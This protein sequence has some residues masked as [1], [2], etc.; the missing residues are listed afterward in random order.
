[1]EE[2]NT[3]PIFEEWSLWDRFQEESCRGKE[4]DQKER[5]SEKERDYEMEEKMPVEDATTIATTIMTTYRWW[6][7]WTCD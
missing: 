5:A 7:W 4:S 2:Q 1:M 6:L 3:S